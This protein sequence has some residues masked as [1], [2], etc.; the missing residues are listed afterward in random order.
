MKKITL[1]LILSYAT[2]CFGGTD[3]FECYVKD[4]KE[5]S[6]NGMIETTHYSKMANPVG[7]KFSIQKKTGQT[8]GEYIN[9]S[10]AITLEVL[11][12]G[13]GS[14][15]FKTIST[16]DGPNILYLEVQDS[17]IHHSKDYS[18]IG[19]RIGSVFSGICK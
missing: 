3:K 11:D 5:V 7:T 2:I 6:D 8:I 12:A 16:Y 17:S 18:F 13:G 9:T 10:G 19:Y 15:N 14:N 1:L 4:S